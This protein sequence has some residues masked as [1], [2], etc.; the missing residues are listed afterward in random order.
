M[1]L[2]RLTFFSISDN[3]NMQ[4]TPLLFHHM[5]SIKECDVILHWMTTRDDS[6]HCCSLADLIL[7]QKF[8]RSVLHSMR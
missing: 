4:I 7:L 8:L 5:R 2:K 6:N 1:L 3:Q